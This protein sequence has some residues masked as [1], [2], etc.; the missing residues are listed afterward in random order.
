ME[1][2]VDIFNAYCIRKKYQG[3]YFSLLKKTYFV[4]TFNVSVTK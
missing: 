4:Y 2:L 3:E 1:K